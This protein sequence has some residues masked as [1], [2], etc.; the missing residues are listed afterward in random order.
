MPSVRKL[1]VEEVK[2]IEGKHKGQRKLVEEEYDQIIKEYGDG[3]YGEAELDPS[4][5]RIT[6]RNRLKA[7]AGR[8]GI[9]LD[10]KRTKGNVL[11]FRVSSAQKASNGGDEG[12]TRSVNGDTTGI[13]QPKR[14]GRG[15]PRASS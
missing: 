13:E 2:Q 12:A 6:V 8:R 10:F 15:R 11:R 1:S 7:A 9:A 5:N 14:R 3:D 4:E